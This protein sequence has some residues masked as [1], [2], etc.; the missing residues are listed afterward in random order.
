MGAGAAGRRRLV[1]ALE[2]RHPPR[3]LDDS[4]REVLPLEGEP[5]PS[6]RPYVSIRFENRHGDDVQF[7]VTPEGDGPWPI[8][9]RPHG[10]PTWLDEDRWNPE[11]QSY[12]DAGFAVAAINYRGSTGRGAA[13]RDALIGDIGGP[14]LEDL[15]DALDHLIGEGSPTPSAPSSGMVLGRYLDADD[16]RQ[17]SRAEVAVR[18]RGRAGRGLRR[19]TT[20]CRRSCRPTTGR[21]WEAGRTRSRS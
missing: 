5:A 13:W 17:A 10:G 11:V 20:T 16:A 15:N 3:I 12:V 19:P 8:L 6:G 21:C 2:R 9:L 18:D 4:G 1:P 14:E 7:L